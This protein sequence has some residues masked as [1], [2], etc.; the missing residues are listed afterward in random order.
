MQHRLYCRNYAAML[1]LSMWI[2]PIAAAQLKFDREA[3]VAEMQRLETICLSIGL[4]EEAE[5]SRAWLPPSRADQ[6]LL[7]LPMEQVAEKEGNQAKW[8]AY[9]NA[10]R[11]KYAAALFD[12]S[13]QLA[14][15][16]DE[17]NAFRVLWRVLREDPKHAEAKRILGTLATTAGVRPRM[18]KG[19]AP[20]TDF[21]WPAGSYSRIQTPHFMLTTRADAK[22]SLE[23]ATSM[24]EYY[25]LW[26]QMFFPLWAAPGVLQKRFAGQNIPWERSSEFA[27]TLLRDRED[28][29]EVLKVAERNAAV[30]V[31]YYAPSIQ[32]SFFYPAAELQATF[33]HELTHQL[34]AEAS[35]FQAAPTAG[36]QAG[37][38]Q[39]EG[40]AMYMESLQN[41]GTYWTVGGID[42]PRLQTARYRALRDGYWVDWQEFTQTGAEAWKQDPQIA[43]LYTHAIGL[44]HL[45]MDQLQQPESRQKFFKS[46]VT[47]YQNQ[48]QFNELFALLGEHNAAAH[49]AY[50]QALKLSDTDIENLCSSGQSCTALVLAASELSPESWQQLASLAPTLE[51][52]DLSFTNAKSED[53]LWL[54]AAKSLK[55]LSLEGTYADARILA[56]IRSLTQLDELDLSGCDID[57]ESLQLIGNHPNLATLWLTKT[58]I[59]DAA[60]QTLDSLIKLQAC[61]VDDTGISSAG[62]R[63]FVRQH[64]SLK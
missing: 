50:Q 42:A 31:G 12:E 34:F 2:C 38:W 39:I 28:Y 10:A 26:R 56:T 33:F 11:S 45:F 20:Q 40:I 3:M 59:T 13:R 48:P 62:W 57:D 6:N 29:L 1:L 7:Y 47:T 51:W 60:L 49:L 37:I 53:L 23:L 44:T 24:E 27:V 16:G 52:L 15:A 63:D 36:N 32:K 17:A 19:T 43:R 21:G 58:K 35:N 46:L 64:P 55:R 8:A 18:R 61:N 22:E 4:T 41:R 25:A 9:F 30:S 14:A 5:I 54:S